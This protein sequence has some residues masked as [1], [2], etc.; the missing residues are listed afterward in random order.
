MDPI[1]T[2]R[3]MLEL[4]AHSLASAAVPQLPPQLG[5]AAAPAPTLAPLCD[6]VL[7]TIVQHYLSRAHIKHVSNERA[8]VIALRLVEVGPLQLP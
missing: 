1:P 2:E 6:Y 7:S 8:A 3:V 4:L 5:A